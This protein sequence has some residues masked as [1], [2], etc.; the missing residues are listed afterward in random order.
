MRNAVEH[1]DEKLLGITKYK[2]SPPFA[3][4]DPYSLRLANTCLVIGADVLTYKELVSAMTKCH[5]T[6]EVIRGVST[7]NPGPAFPNARLRT[8]PGTPVPSTSGLQ[9]TNNLQELIRLM[10]THS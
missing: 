4:V 8:D 7:S 10:T 9:P 1:S 6:I 3:N 2:N 5:K